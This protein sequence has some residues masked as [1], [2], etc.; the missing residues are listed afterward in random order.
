M[1]IKRRPCDRVGCLEQSSCCSLFKLRHRCRF[2]LTKRDLISKTLSRLSLHKEAAGERGELSLE[3]EVGWK[4]NLGDVYVLRVPLGL[5]WWQEKLR[6]VPL[7]KLPAAA[8]VRAEGPGAVPAS[9]PPSLLSKG[10][11]SAAS[12]GCLTDCKD[13]Y[14]EKL[15]WEFNKLAAVRSRI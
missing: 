15:L 9:P 4:A 14:L 5:S 1:L 2:A 7:D 3:R 6:I 11:S 13:E 10:S 12:R 8:P